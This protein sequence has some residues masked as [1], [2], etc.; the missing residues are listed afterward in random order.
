[1]KFVIQR[2]ETNKEAIN[3]WNMSWRIVLQRNSLRKWTED[4]RTENS[5]L[6]GKVIRNGLTDRVT[7]EQ[8]PKKV[9]SVLGTGILNRENHHCQDS[10]ALRWK[11]PGSRK[12]KKAERL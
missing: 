9:R 11:F 10:E 8:R 4:T 2:E 6:C 7:F 12:S 5:T 3:E 1:M